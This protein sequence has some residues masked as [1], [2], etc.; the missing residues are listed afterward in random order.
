[1]KKRL[2]V[3]LV[4]GLF[5]IGIVGVASAV[6]INGG[7]ETGDLT[8][9]DSNGQAGVQTDIVHDGSYAAW[10]GT[11]DFDQNDSNDFTG[12]T[13]T[14]GYTN[15]WIS[16]T[17]DVAGMDEFNL[18]YNFYTWDYVDWDDPG[19]EIQI[20]GQ[21][22]L[23]I[24]AGDISP[25]NDGDLDSTDWTLFTYDLSNYSQSTLELAIYAG[26]TEDANVQSWVYID[27]TP[28]A[29]VPE[30]ATMLLFGTGLAG[31]V[32]LRRRKNKK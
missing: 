19:F 12:E 1:M 20:N 29:P 30:P 27:A 28:N 10:I 23:T 8:G 14:E 21:S 32:G 2:L 24:S 17:F 9:W 25:T 6:P 15:N 7:F 13:G 3:S 18:W 26:N 22:E 4:T 16:Q 11:V 5:L 31:L